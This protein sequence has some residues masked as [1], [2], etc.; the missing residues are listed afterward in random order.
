MA[1]H[2][3]GH[4]RTWLLGSG[5]RGEVSCCLSGILSTGGAIIDARPGHSSDWGWGAF[6]MASQSNC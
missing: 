6:L 4:G 1:W 3:K 5:F 2:Y